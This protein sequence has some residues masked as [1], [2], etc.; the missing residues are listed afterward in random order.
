MDMEI[1]ESAR[2]AGCFTYVGEEFYVDDVIDPVIVKEIRV[3]DPNYV[4][5]LCK[6]LYVSPLGMIVSKQ[7]HVIG[8]HIEFPQE[9]YETENV[10]L[11]I[12]PKGFPFNPDKIQPLRTLCANWPKGSLEWIIAA[13]PA[14]VKPGKW[15]VEQM[16]AVHK[17]FDL[18]PSIGKDKKGRTGRQTTQDKLNEILHAEEKRDEKV[19]AEAMADARYRARHNWRHLKRA[20]DQGRINP[21]PPDAPKPFVD[22][23]GSK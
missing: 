5:L 21:E 7:Y 3:F 9:G 22:L 11:A 1:H 4:P 8:R 20:W 13:P 16:Q 10:R 6:R 15:L 19:M 18:G 12:V 23:K 17:C 2:A 14:E